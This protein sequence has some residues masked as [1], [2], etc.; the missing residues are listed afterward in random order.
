MGTSPRGYEGDSSG[1]NATAGTALA[2]GA[3]VG[4]SG[5]SGGSDYSGGSIGNIGLPV[6]DWLVRIFAQPSRRATAGT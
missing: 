1:G 3:A 5:A 6:P 4:C 2:A